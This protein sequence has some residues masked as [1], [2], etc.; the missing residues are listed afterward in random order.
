[1]GLATGTLK[2]TAKAFDHKILRWFVDVRGLRS[3]LG[4]DCECAVLLS[5]SQQ[6]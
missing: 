3:V 1:M 2:D 5:L 4:E 6:H